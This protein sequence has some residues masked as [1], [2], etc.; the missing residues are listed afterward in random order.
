MIPRRAAGCCTPW[1]G[2]IRELGQQL[3]KTGLLC[4]GTEDFSTL[5]LEFCHLC[6]EPCRRL[7]ISHS[8]WKVGL[9]LLRIS[10]RNP[11]IY[12]QISHGEG[13]CGSLGGGGRKKI[14][15]RLLHWSTSREP[16]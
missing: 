4:A 1:R 14:S 3:V 15:P 5:V 13:T 11:H 10:W 6:F 8:L 12:P 2:V 7:R 9:Q 16:T